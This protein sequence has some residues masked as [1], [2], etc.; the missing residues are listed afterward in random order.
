MRWLG[1]AERFLA[2]FGD[3][4]AGTATIEA[5]QRRKDC[6]RLGT[7]DPIV[8]R[9]GGASRPDQTITAKTRKMLRQR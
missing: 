2:E 5:M 7:S 9:L 3:I 1:D 6:R 4:A 8:D